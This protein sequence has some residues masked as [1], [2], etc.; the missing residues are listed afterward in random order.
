MTPNKNTLIPK[1]EIYEAAKHKDWRK[2]IGLKYSVGTPGDA[3]WIEG[4]DWRNEDLSDMPTDFIVLY[5]CNVENASFKGA[6][7]F[8]F[9]LWNCNAKGLDITNTDGMLFA[10]QCDL[11]DLKYEGSNL[12]P[13]NTDLPSAFEQCKTDEEFREF[14][15]QQGALMSFP[16]SK[17]IPFSDFGVPGGL[18]GDMQQTFLRGELTPDIIREYE[19]KG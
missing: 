6:H 5:N 19:N 16:S 1:Q 13:A 15:Q 2:I 14:A 4:V 18:A 9:A 7:F 11:R 8:P 12:F 17:N 10:F 3:F